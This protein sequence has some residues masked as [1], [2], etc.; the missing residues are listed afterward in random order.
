MTEDTRHSSWARLLS[1]LRALSR[2][3]LYA[4]QLCELTGVAES[5]LRRD[6]LWLER[7]WP[8]IRTARA[9]RKKLYSYV[10]TPLGVDHD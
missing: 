1:I 2:H 6:M 9:G 10:H 5:T 4:Y 3:P 8:G 7:N